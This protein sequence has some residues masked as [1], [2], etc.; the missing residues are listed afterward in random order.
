MAEAAKMEL[1]MI[2]LGRM[3]AAMTERLIRKG[4][5]VIA[6]DRAQAAMERVARAGAQAVASLSE[7]RTA[8][9][10]PRIIWIMAPAGAAVD[11]ILAELLPL[12]EPGDILIDGGNSYFRDTLRRAAAV[13][14]GV[15][16]V[17]VGVS[18]G[19]WGGAEG[20]CLMI[21]G[22]DAAVRNLRPIFEALAPDA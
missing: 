1:A 6:F 22:P 2:G 4:H 20:Y 5:R 8:L 9:P 10:A 14:A 19:I 16:Y 13:P 18:G 7:L 15:H 21:G 11:E 3:G 17:D 12:V